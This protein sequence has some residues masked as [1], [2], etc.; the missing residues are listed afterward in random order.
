MGRKATVSYNLKST[1]GMLNTHE[2][3]YSPELRQY[4]QEELTEMLYYFGYAKPAGQENP[5]GFFEFS[6]EKAENVA[7]FKQFERDS[8]AALDRICQPGYKSTQM[9]ETNAG[10]ILPMFTPDDLMNV[11]TPGYTY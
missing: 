2:D 10:D 8:Q 1:T 4:V 11:Q 6:E 3:K 5:T 9:Y 7:R